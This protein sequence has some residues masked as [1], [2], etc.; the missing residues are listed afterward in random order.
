MWRGTTDRSFTVLFFLLGPW[1]IEA[2]ACG[3]DVVVVWLIAIELFSK[4]VLI[5]LFFLDY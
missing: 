5:F 2:D 3:H 4:H 1:V